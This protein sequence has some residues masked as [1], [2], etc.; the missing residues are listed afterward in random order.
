MAFGVAYNRFHTTAMCSPAR[1]CVLTGR[2]HHAVGFGQIPEYS[3][4]FDGYIGEIP[5]GAATVAQV[6]GEYG[7][8]TAAFGKWHNTPANEVNRTGPFDRWPT[9]MGFDYF[10]GFMAAETSQ[11]EPR[12]FENTTPIEPPHDPDYHL[13]EDMA[14][15]AIDYLRRQRNTRPEAPVFLYFTPGA[16]HG[17]HHVPTEWA[18]KYA[19]AFDDGWE[20][21]REQT[22]ERQRALGWI[23]D[24]A[25]L[26]PINPTMQRWENVPEAERRFQT[27]LMEVY[28]GFLEHTDRQYGKVLDELERMGELDNT[29]VFYINSDNGASAEGLFGTIS[30]ILCHN[31]F[32]VMPAEQ[33][34]VLDRDYGGLDSLGSAVS[35]PM[36]H[37][38]WA[39]AGETPF[40]STKLV[41]AH[42]GGTRTPL[43]VSWP[44]GFAPDPVPRSQFHHVID[45]AATIYDVVGIEAPGSFYGADQDPID[46]VSMARS[47]HDANA[48]TGRQTQYFEIMGSRGV[49]H[50]GWFA[51]A[52]GPRNPWDS[53]YSRLKDWDPDQDQWELYDLTND[54]SQA[55]DLAETH[56]AKLAELR[57]MFDRHAEANHVFPI[58][59]GLL[60][61]VYRPD[62]MRSTPIR[63]WNFGGDDDRIAESMAPKFTS[64]TSSRSTIS[65]TG[66]P[67]DEGVL[68]CVGG[69]TGGFT[70]YVQNGVLR[71]EYNAGGIYRTKAVAAGAMNPGEHTAIVEFVSDGG[72]AR[73]PAD[74]R[75][76]LDGE[77]VAQAR[78]PKTMPA[79][80]SFSETFDVGK[81]LGSPVALDYM[82]ER[83]FVFSGEVH[84]VHCEYT[85]PG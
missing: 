46:G 17:P 78:V 33:T 12:L 65:F 66:G 53:S 62:L 77:L 14:A 25:E 30:E 28:A 9:G 55:R 76:H 71:A 26:T 8:A 48:G 1:A 23:P 34:E 70:V 21:L 44:K 68:F 57:E 22:Y 13:T 64:G 82:H 3:T 43:A 79:M 41:A 69:V 60:S 63:S 50:E 7:Y 4:D 42:F 2:N 29:L 16:V 32:R 67:H 39:W 45:I 61:S 27:R 24:D 6:L 5:A 19:G 31:G 80:F 81:D 35:D 83:P 52:F 56:P 49:Y 15:R 74:I 58:G 85:E 73:C 10:Y 37:A 59:A 75:L 40:K 36:Y 84:S 18:D 54:F 20:A 38:G 72:R 51:G 11:Y 47:F